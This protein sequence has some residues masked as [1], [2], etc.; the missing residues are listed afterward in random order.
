MIRGMPTNSFKPKI[1]VWECHGFRHP[2]LWGLTPPRWSLIHYQWSLL[3]E[4]DGDGSPPA[5]R[6]LP[7]GQ[8][9]EMV[10][11]SVNARAGDDNPT[12]RARDLRPLDC[13][14]HIYSTT[15]R[16]SWG[17]H[18]IL[19]LKIWL[20]ILNPPSWTLIRSRVRKTKALR[21]FMGLEEEGDG[22]K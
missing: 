13:P 12:A 19:K 9:R 15:W 4:A 20:T 17:A 18:A 2:L 14:P 21:F 3:V 16:H 8:S 11:P 10:T 5:G 7:A 1:I 6:H 22:S